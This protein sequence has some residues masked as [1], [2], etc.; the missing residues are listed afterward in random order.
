MVLND[1][2][3]EHPKL[4]RAA[5][6]VGLAEALAL[7]VVSIGYAR[8][9]LTDGFIPDTFV[10]TSA[11]GSDP[12]AVAR[13][14]CARSVRLFHRTRGGYVIH[15]YLQH[16][17]TAENVKEIRGKNRERMA[18]WRARKNGGA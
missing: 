7:Y 2:L 15:D 8:R 9:H 17:E 6:K 13:A 4:L 11:I 5:A 18:A 3:P 1:A 10:Q 16:N 14:F 12:Q